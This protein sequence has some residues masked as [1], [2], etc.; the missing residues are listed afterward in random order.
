MP[1]L[2]ENANPRAKSYPGFVPAD[3]V[4][5]ARE[6]AG[7]NFDRVILHAPPRRLQA[8]STTTE[9]LEP[10]ADALT[11]FYLTERTISHPLSQVATYDE[12]PAIMREISISASKPTLLWHL[13]CLKHPRKSA[14]LWSEWGGYAQE[15]VEAS[16]LQSLHLQSRQAPLEK[17]QNTP[18]WR[19]Y[20]VNDWLGYSQEYHYGSDVQSGPTRQDVPV[21]AWQHYSPSYLYAW[22]DP[23]APVGEWK[24]EVE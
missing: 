15:V 10:K 19:V 7:D 11:R 20:F 4:Q 5:N 24:H 17:A 3:P 14:E 6:I 16:R 21:E 1:K 12:D 8:R 23:P 22:K 9:H 18:P 13:A 2:S